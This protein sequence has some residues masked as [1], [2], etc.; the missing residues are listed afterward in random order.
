MGSIKLSDLCDSFKKAV[1]IDFETKKVW[2]V[3]EGGLKVYHKKSFND[4][5]S[6]L[7]IMDFKNDI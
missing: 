7:D 6:R 1:I 3:R 5:V 2:V 4:I